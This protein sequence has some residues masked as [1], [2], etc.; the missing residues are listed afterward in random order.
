MKG[1]KPMALPLIPE[2]T[3]PPVF[4]EGK[5]SLVNFLK[6]H[7]V[8]IPHWGEESG[9][10]PPGHMDLT[11]GVAIRQDFPD[12]DQLLATACKDFQRF[13]EEARIPAGGEGLLSTELDPTLSG[14]DFLLEITEKKITL[15]GATTEGIRRGLYYLS[16]KIASGSTPFLPVGS[17]KKHF[18]LKNRISRCFFGPIK[19]PPFFRDELM[20]DIDYYPEEYL[21]QLARE[22]INGLWLTI[23]FSEICKTFLLKENPDREKRL[24]K[25]RTTVQRCLR[26][27]IKT[28][29]FCIEPTNWNKENNPLPEGYEDLAGPGFEQA[30]TSGIGN[31]QTFCSRTEKAQ[32]Y[33]YESTY[34]IFSAVPG[35]GGMIVLPLGE[36][37]SSCVSTKGTGTIKCQSKCGLSVAEIFGNVLNPMFKGLR[38]ANP[39]ADMITWIYQPQPG[40]MPDWIYTLPEK[41]HKD[42]IFT[43]NFESGVKKT[44]LGKIHNGGDYWLS[45][46]GPSDR[47]GRF[48]AKVNNHCQLGAKLQVACSHEIAT[49]PFVPVPGALHKKYTIM[50][51]NHVSSV[52][53]CWFFGN[54]P[55]IMNQ[56][57]GLLA[58]EDFSASEEEF[59]LKL[60]AV[61]WGPHA[62]QVVKAWQLFEK[63]YSYY[64]LENQFQYYGP[65]H[66]GTVW[67]LHLKQVLRQLPRTWKPDYDAAGDVLGE[68]LKS[69]TPGEAT[70]LL[71]K[72]RTLFLQG[73][74]LLLPLKKTFAH[75]PVR[76]REIA[77][78]EAMG[79]LITSASN[80]FRFYSMRSRLFKGAKNQEELLCE[81]E[82]I[83]Q[84]EVTNTRILAELN[85]ND[86]RLGYHSE[87]EV[88]KFYPERLLWRAS[89]LEKEIRP[90][91]E[92]CRAALRAGKS[93]EE[94][95][96]RKDLKQCRCSTWYENG[97]LR[98]KA[99]RTAED[100]HVEVFCSNAEDAHEEYLKFYFL[101]LEGETFPV[102]NT[103]LARRSNE[104]VDLTESAVL[105][106]EEIP[107]GWKVNASFPLALFRGDQRIL[108]GVQMVYYTD[109]G[110]RNCT[111][112][113]GEFT[114]ELRLNLS[115][116]TPDR[117]ALLEL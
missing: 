71:G 43:Y 41:L 86:P 40:Q 88:A 100:L 60:A 1:L 36:R 19:R 9:S 14:E 47:F 77:V 115:Y 102:P 104:K 117:L 7:P 39:Q 114:N 69:H 28:W 16:D 10:C 111:Y 52:M 112:P 42:I 103:G 31:V 35:L 44:Q 72:M 15:K 25:L 116:F 50:H 97:T 24:A 55:G 84:E 37:I 73:L 109:Q 78:A 63:A 101:D 8:F 81:M 92:E 48:A 13:L 90:Q 108:F 110:E 3:Q 66:D 61:N 85:R 51:D 89:V 82:K 54:C 94:F 29:I 107:G 113:P 18:W 76:L 57:S 30:L 34:S 22:G 75:D 79:I 11:K 38:D 46:I 4:P 59:L 5:D 70:I 99:E 106:K 87:A 49:V 2:L 33:L 12:P 21:S 27:G 64:P 6:T 80:I 45:C 56:A 96:R 58:C 91:F 74:E 98:W 17:E 95:A 93:F 53:Q 83:L 32:R 23:K 68:A 105:H 65:M 26:Y 62:P 67:P 20:D